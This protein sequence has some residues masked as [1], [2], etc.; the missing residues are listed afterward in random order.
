MCWSGADV[1]LLGS[2]S[3]DGK[4]LSFAD[5]VTGALAVRN[6]ADG[7]SHPI[8]T[9]PAGSHEFAYFSVFSRDGRN[10]AY[11]WFNQQGFYDLRVTSV[12]GGSA[13]RVL[14]RNEDAGFVQPCSWTPDGKQILTLLFRR[15]NI[16]QIALVPAA[17]G[18]PRVL[19][20]LD[21]VYP[22]KMDI[23]PDGRW[24]VY[25]NF[26]ADGKTDRTIFLLATDGSEERR[27]VDM[28]GNYLFPLWMPDG[29]S[30]VFAGDHNGPEELWMLP[31]EDGHAKGP[32]HRVPGSLG[33]FLP[34]GMT[35]SSELFCGVRTGTPDVFIASITDPR[36]P[37]RASVRFVGRNRSPAWSADGSKLAYLSRRGT[38]NFG[39][40][41]YTIVVLDL[42]S[43]E[44]REVP[45]QLADIDHVT[46]SPDGS[47]LLASGSDGKGRGGVFAVRVLD[48]KTT[49]VATEHGAPFRGFE[50]VW[51]RDG[52]SVY[53][54]HGETELRQHRIVDGTENVVLHAE[55]MRGLAINPAGDT[56]AV[57]IAGRAIRLTPLTAGVKAR[58]IPFPGL[59]EL[60][61]G[62]DL[63]AGAGVGLW[64]MPLDGGKPLPVPV[65]SGRQPG[66]SVSPDGNS[67]AYGVGYDQS[68]VVSLELPRR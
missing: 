11:A 8:A 43:K 49:P 1:T 21:W 14:Y 6:L 13:P 26:A 68:Q 64:A 45:A 31:V 17:G 47:T 23:S 57:G 12:A 3:R 58:L 36:N 4:W 66:V 22:K 62:K 55:G 42:A 9:R 46:W 32:P 48:G 34:L 41:T 16:S 20:S 63:Y 65:P 67:I 28:P 44:E 19:R 52:K 53:Y 51:A 30:I 54:L 40:D 37:V 38:E 56:L 15:D 50:A 59:T 2:P 61:W 33:R 29:R 35:N 10:V 25:D 24:I 18:P 60:A 7:T 39:Q 5:P 27:L